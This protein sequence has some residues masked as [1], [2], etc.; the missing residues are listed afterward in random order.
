LK[1]CFNYVLAKETIGDF[2]PNVF[3]ELLNQPELQDVYVDLNELINLPLVGSITND[4]NLVVKALKENKKF[5]LDEEKNIIKVQLNDRTTI[6]LRDI[7]EDTPEEDIKILFGEY[8]EHITNMQPEYGRNFYVNFDS[9]GVTQEAFNYVRTKTFNNKNVGCCITTNFT[10]KTGLP[11]VYVPPEYQENPYKNNYDYKDKKK[12]RNKRKDFRKMGSTNNNSNGRGG[13]RPRGKKTRDF[14]SEQI[15]DLGEYWPPLPNSNKNDSKISDLKKYTIEQIVA[16]VDSLKDIQPPK[17]EQ[18][19]VG[20]SDVINSE[21][22]IGKVLPSSYKSEWVEKGKKKKTRQ[23]SKSG[24][25]EQPPTN[26][27][28]PPSVPIWPGRKHTKKEYVI[29]QTDDQQENN[30][31]ENNPNNLPNETTTNENQNITNESHS[32][33]QQNKT[34]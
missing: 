15:Q 7:P 1:D 20:I 2:F 28:E 26:Q 11:Y 9:T 12:Y 22:E 31:Q 23:R 21:L 19:C 24:K 4:I 6:M 16:V 17:W 18:E 13:G 34:N 10:H 33:T 30:Q 8:A 29:K 27:E 25:K 32:E 5:T 3:N 14:Q